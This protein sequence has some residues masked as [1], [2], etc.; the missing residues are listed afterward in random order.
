MFSR[1]FLTIL[2]IS[3]ILYSLVLQ[4][5]NP[6][7]LIDAIFSFVNIWAVIGIIFI[8]FAAKPELK[9]RIRIPVWV[10]VIICLFAC[11]AV[12]NFCMIFFPIPE[13]DAGTK[14]SE[15]L[16]LLG[17][18]ITKDGELVI[19]VQNRIATAAV[20][21]A[22]HPETIC[23][24]T[25]GTLDHLK[26]AES[27][28]I[29]TALEKSG[30]DANRIIE[31]SEALDTIQN[32]AYS[33]AVICRNENRTMDEVLSMP[34]ILVTSRFHM[35]RALFIA[36]RSGFTNVSGIPA[37]TPLFYIPHDYLREIAAWFKLEL[38]ILFTGK[39]TLLQQPL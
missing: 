8:L 37:E 6:N 27:P 34:V 10:I 25:G 38:R 36:R 35:N 16:L 29:K 17:G 13:S 31:E 24:V 26:Y 18:G 39:P 33:A 12:I 15:Y 11:S 21:L 3:G 1:I 7:P 4:V 28:A 14:T 19:P 20:Y 32:I 5:L 30:I 22:D 23:I 9:K 2:G